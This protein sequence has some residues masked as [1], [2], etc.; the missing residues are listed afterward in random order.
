MRRLIGPLSFLAF[1][2]A[3]P[4]A[5]SELHR[6]ADHRVYTDLEGAAEEHLQRHAVDLDLKHV[7]LVERQAVA[8]RSFR[9]VRFEQTYAGLPVIGGQAAVRI[10]ADGRVRATML[11]VARD[12]NVTTI[13]SFPRGDAL[14]LA[15]ARAGLT[16]SVTSSARLAV[17]PDAANGLL[18]WEVDVP[19]L[20]GGWRFWI[21][22]HS[23]S[24]IHERPLAVH[25]LG[26]VYPVSSVTTPETQDLELLDLL[27]MTPQRLTGWDGHLTVTN[28][29]SGDSQSG[30]YVLEQTLG[31][32]S[33]E[34][35]L[36]APPAVDTDPNDGFAQV[37]IYYHLTRMRD[38]AQ[39]TLGV[40]MSA[41]S[42]KLVAVANMKEGGAAM[43]NA[44]FSPIGA[45]APFSAPNMIAIG[46][47][48]M[49]DF[50]QD[51]DVFNHEFTHY[52]TE[53]AVGYNAGQYH[54]DSWGMSHFSG[55]IDEG[56]SDYF[57]STVNGDA[58]LGEASLKLL[59]SGRDLAS[60]WRVCP[61]NLDGEVHADGQIIGSIAWTLREDLGAD[62]ADELVWGAVT[63]LPFAASFGDFADG[64]V[65]SAEDM[66]AA[67]KMSPEQRDRVSAVLAERGLDDCGRELVLDASADVNLAGLGGWCPQ[68]KQQGF[69]GQSM[70]HYVVTPGEN[71]LGIRI[72]VDIEGLHEN[73]EPLWS[74]YVRAG[75]HVAFQPSFPPS[76][77]TYD[78]ALENVAVENGQLVIDELASPAFDPNTTY[79]LVITHQQCS[80]SIAQVSVS[81]ILTPPSTDDGDPG[82]GGADA[83]EPEELDET[84]AAQ[85]CACRTRGAPANDAGWILALLAAAALRRRRR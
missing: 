1:L 82:A 26:T 62:I 33:G 56:V 57:S 85:G 64:L 53:N 27:P 49:F 67:G 43:N 58:F 75:E 13:A 45:G 54:V 31:P 37:G 14:E 19:T 4:A 25:A 41:D 20:D 24:L 23:G 65:Q 74:V 21:D 5:A 73:D 2:C 83:T 80:N 66:F 16:T 79:H 68:A 6:S 51:S 3:S 15:A 22:A 35:F 55:A 46:Q 28:Y 70:F 34:D 63:L 81:D 77:F 76:V 61:D 78:H 17:L 40:D 12:L 39:E 84:V 47:G 9:T 60:T 18:I 38:F 36:Y 71:A 7:T 44:F 72:D 10:G 11:N 42:W 48:S 8:A 29:V 59:G 30:N 32:S 52:L 50:A 69:T